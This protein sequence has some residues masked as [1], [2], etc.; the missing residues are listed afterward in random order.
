MKSTI[1]WR[2]WIVVL[3]ICPISRSQADSPPSVENFIRNYRE[4]ATLTERTYRGIDMSFRV[5][6][7]GHDPGPKDATKSVMRYSAKD[8]KCRVDREFLDGDKM[9]QGFVAAG[10]D[11]FDVLRNE[12]GL[13]YRLNS[14]GAT[15]FDWD[16]AAYMC[17]PAFAP[18]AIDDVGFATLLGKRGFR[19]EAIESVGE[20]DEERVTVRWRWNWE[21]QKTPS[22]RGETTFWPAGNWVITAYHWQQQLEDGSWVPLESYAEIDYGARIDDVPITARVKAGYRPLEEGGR[23]DIAIYTVESADPSKSTAKDFTPS[24]FGLGY[25]ESTARSRPGL[26]LIATGG[27]GLLVLA[28]GRLLWARRARA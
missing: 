24:A 22:R 25:V 1:I 13:S 21:G 23:R 20:G 8:G 4:H 11:S 3:A 7:E 10:A 6:Y 2:P 18:Y 27:V 15:A 16:Q 17:P 19:I 28:A 9:T 26:P 14:I 12:D 5:L